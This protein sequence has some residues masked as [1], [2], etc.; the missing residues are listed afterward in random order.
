M[1]TGN[2]L[3]K[4]SSQR[5]ELHGVDIS[6][7][8]LKIARKKHPYI[9]YHQQ[10]MA[11]FRINKKFDV[12][13]AIFDAVNY[14][15]DFSQ[16]K[17]LFKRVKDHLNTDGLFIFNAYTTKAL[18][19]FKARKDYSV[20]TFFDKGIMFDKSNIKGNLLEWEVYLF[21]RISHHKFQLHKYRSKERIFNHQKIRKA[22]LKHL[23][24]LEI[25]DQHTQEEV[26]PKTSKI[27]YVCR[28]PVSNQAHT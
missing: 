21:E 18:S 11:E 20:S 3:G 10:D 1:G 13:F 7:D 16:W 9:T 26:T 24:I 19:D 12:I 23:K 27:M 14:L 15:L 2:V 6:E 22:L 28:K 17:S 4:F 8:Y 25:M 5:F